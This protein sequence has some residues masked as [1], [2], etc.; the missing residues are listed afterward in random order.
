MGLGWAFGPVSVEKAGFGLIGLAAPGVRV[1]LGC[2]IGF[3]SGLSRVGFLWVEGWLLWVW[4]WF[5]LWLGLG[6]LGVV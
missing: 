4:S 1:G 2:G 6:G 3:A 5:R